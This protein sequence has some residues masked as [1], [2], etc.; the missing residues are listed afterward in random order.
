MR[1]QM[2]RSTLWGILDGV[3]QKVVQDLPDLR[4]I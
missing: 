4:M 2:Q 3:G 1:L